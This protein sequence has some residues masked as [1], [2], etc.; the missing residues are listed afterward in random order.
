MKIDVQIS[1]HGPVAGGAMAQYTVMTHFE[2][3]HE[4]MTM[5]VVIANTG[6]EASRKMQAVARAKELARYFY[7]QAES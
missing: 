5:S 2:G 7:E 6:D 4:A 1:G 3:P